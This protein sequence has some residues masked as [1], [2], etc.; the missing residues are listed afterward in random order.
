MSFRLLFEK[1]V[2]ILSESDHKSKNDVLYA[3][4]EKNK[5]LSFPITDECVA[6]LLARDW[7][8]DLLSVYYK[9]RKIKDL[10]NGLNGVSIKVKTIKNMRLRTLF[11]VQLNEKDVIVLL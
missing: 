9:D 6:H 3:I 7:N 11:D 1:I 8:I 10:V 5:Q 4:K 2:G